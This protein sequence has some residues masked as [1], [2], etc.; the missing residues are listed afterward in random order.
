MLVMNQ[1]NSSPLRGGSATEDMAQ[2][3]KER[4]N[5]L[6]H[7]MSSPLSKT[8]VVNNQQQIRESKRQERLRQQREERHSRESDE[9]YQKR[10]QQQAEAFQVD[11]DTLVDEEQE[12]HYQESGHPQDPEQ[13]EEELEDYLTEADLELEAQLKSMNIT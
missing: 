3:Q 4:G 7:P 10:L 11:V 6:Y 12:Q 5:A 13:Y 9:D 8:K 1:W 2:A